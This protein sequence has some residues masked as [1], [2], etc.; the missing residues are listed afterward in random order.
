MF[1]C[2]HIYD[3]VFFLSVVFLPVFVICALCCLLAF[4]ANKKLIIMLTPNTNLK[5]RINSMM[6]KDRSTK[7]HYSP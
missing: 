5:Y 7:K 1:V 6:K 4:L 2:S 3:S